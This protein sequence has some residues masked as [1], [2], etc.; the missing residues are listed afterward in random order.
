[1]IKFRKIVKRLLPYNRSQY[2]KDVFWDDNPSPKWYGVSI[3]FK[4]ESKKNNLSEY[5][6]NYTPLFQTIVLK[7]GR[8]SKWIVNHDDKDLK[9]FS[10]EGNTVSNLRA[11]FKQNNIP[12][13]FRG[14]LVFTTETLLKYSKEIVSY[15]YAVSDINGRLYKNLDVS[16]ANLPIII[17]ISGHLNIDLLSPDKNI[18]KEAIENNIPDMFIIKQYRGTKL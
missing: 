15:P 3:Q 13:S 5:L 18:L 12:N 10:F 11:L 16:L 4:D 2:I 8:N 6:E 17:K 7:Y 9:W 14:A 1:M